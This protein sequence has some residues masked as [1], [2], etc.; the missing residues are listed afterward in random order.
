[1]KVLVHIILKLPTQLESLFWRG[2]KQIVGKRLKCAKTVVPDLFFQRHI[3][4]I[5]YQDLE[6]IKRPYGHI[7]FEGLRK[8]SMLEY[9]EHFQ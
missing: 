1:M 8:F 9:L 3:Y 6:N 2:N 5:D 4:E 7:F